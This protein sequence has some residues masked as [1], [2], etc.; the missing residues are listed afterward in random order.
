MHFEDPRRVQGWVQLAR[1]KRY[2]DITG[3]CTITTAEFD[4]L[5]G[6]LVAVA[7]A[8]ASCFAAE[9]IAAYP[10]AKAILNVR[11]LDYKHASTL[12]NVCTAINDVWAVRV[13]WFHQTL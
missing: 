6:H 11:D 4:R 5:L 3:D 7:D 13:C 1:K 9:L 2:S 10:D 12:K 8:A